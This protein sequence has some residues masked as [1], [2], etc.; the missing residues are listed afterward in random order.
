MTETKTTQGATTAKRRAP[1][2]RAQLSREKIIGQALALLETIQ[3]EEL[4]MTAIAER[5]G[6][7]TMSLYKYFPNREAL[8]NATA[9][10]TFALFAV[11][12]PEAGRWQQ[13]L[14]AW[15]GAL[16][17]HLDRHPTML[18]VIGWEGRV[19]GAWVRVI[20]PVAQLLSEQGL[21]EERLAFVLVWF[22]SSA[23]GLLR[24]ETIDA[25]AYRQNYSLGALD[26]LSLKEQQTFLSLL[27]YLPGTDRE[28]VM[29]FGLQQLV[30]TLETLLAQPARAAVPIGKRRRAAPA[31]AKGARKS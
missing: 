18:K 7:T 10:H 13:R 21:K 28:R 22:M 27:P 23:M 9:E 1:G 24:T 2:R 14:L 31:T 5:L 6:T 19:S 4:T 20:A 26:C 16:Q 25:P 8:L 3:A 15:L 29:E 11:A 30:A 17:Q 12:M